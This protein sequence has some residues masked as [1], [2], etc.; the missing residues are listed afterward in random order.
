MSDMNFENDRL[1]LKSALSSA[2]CADLAATQGYLSLDHQIVLRVLSLIPWAFDGAPPSYARVESHPQQHDW[3]G[4]N[5]K[6]M[7]WCEISAS[8]LLTPQG[9]GVFKFKD[10]PVAL[11]PGDLLTWRATPENIH[12]RSQHDGTRKAL[13]IFLKTKQAA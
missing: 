13:L 10:G 2:D 5:A 1:H 6:H 9:S 4:D 11:E 3:H 7:P 12:A 8:V